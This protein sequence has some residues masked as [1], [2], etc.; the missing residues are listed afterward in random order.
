MYER[1]LGLCGNRQRLSCQEEAKP[2]SVRSSCGNHERQHQ[3]KESLQILRGCKHSVGDG[4]YQ[5]YQYYFYYI[6]IIYHVYLCYFFACQEVRQN[7]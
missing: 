2:A 5:V 4:E 1:C 7:S 6:Y 3:R